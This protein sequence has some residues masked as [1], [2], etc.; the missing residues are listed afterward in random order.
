[1]INCKHKALLPI[2]LLLAVVTSTVNAASVHKWVD[3]SGV[4]HYSD[5][6]PENNSKSNVQVVVTKI[7]VSDD[8]RTT[9]FH[10]DYYSVTNQWAR[11]KEERI[12]RKQ[13][14]L[15][16]AKQQAAQKQ[17]APQVVYVNEFEEDNRR[18]SYPVYSRFNYISNRYTGQ[19]NYGRYNG[20]KC[21]YPTIR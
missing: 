3:A 5:Q 16:K 20:Y 12:E 19:K 10:N 2:V 18:S 11:M 1:M 9:S 4:T 7:N 17:V 6:A 14:Q 13:L 15:E 8:Y 21:D